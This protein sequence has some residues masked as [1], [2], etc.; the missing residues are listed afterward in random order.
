LHTNQQSDIDVLDQ[1]CH[2]EKLGFD[3]W[4][5]L[6]EMHGQSLPKGRK[7]YYDASFME[8]DLPDFQIIAIAALKG[9]TVQRVLKN[10]HII[11]LKEYD[12][13]QRLL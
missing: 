12:Q 3:N 7:E 8:A 4:S 1:L 13:L 2:N 10:W 5:N 6:N 11:T 9:R